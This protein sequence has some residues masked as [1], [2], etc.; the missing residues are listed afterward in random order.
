[1]GAQ[2]VKNSEIMNSD[3]WKVGPTLTK[4]KI[5]QL[6]DISKENI[7]KCTHTEMK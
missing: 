2:R 1:M 6:E 7:L 5:S 4:Y 3:G